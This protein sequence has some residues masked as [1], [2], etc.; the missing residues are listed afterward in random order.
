[1]CI[2]SMQTVF[3]TN[4]IFSVKFDVTINNVPQR[5][6]LRHAIHLF[7]QYVVCVLFT[8]CRALG[9]PCRSVTNFRS[10]HDSDASVTIDKY[11]NIAG[12]QETA[13]PGLDKDEIW[14]GIMNE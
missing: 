11:W 5:Q 2:V 8:V 12:N 14:Y 13:F 4:L 7:G 6:M 1:M 3:H 10:A 9:L